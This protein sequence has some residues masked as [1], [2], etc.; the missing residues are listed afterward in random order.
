MAQNRCLSSPLNPFVPLAGGTEGLGGGDSAWVRT[1]EPLLRQIGGGHER[2]GAGYYFDSRV[3]KDEPH[4]VLQLTLSGAGFFE[5]RRRRTV[6]YPGMAFLHQIPGDFR[7]GYAPET[8]RDLH[9]KFYEQ[10]FISLAGSGSRKSSVDNDSAA[11]WY[12]RIT[13]THGHVLNFGEQN[14]IAPLLLRLADP[15]PRIMPRDR[16][17]ASAQI[18]QLLM[19]IL[20]TLNESRLAAT[21][22]VR[23]AVRLVNM[24]AAEGEFSIAGLAEALDCSR[25]HLTR[26]FRSALGV[27][28]AEYLMQQ[29]LRLVTQDL[30]STH[31][32]LDL[33]A[34]RCGFAGANY[35]CRAFRKH[36]GVSPAEFRARPWLLGP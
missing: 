31:D 18:Y 10:V 7:Y 22:L 15:V 35:L 34:Q 3:R 6:L 28:P 30:R 14:L 9:H 2:C 4:I 17:L 29:R 19:T 33:V 23:Q 36:L 25:E 16:Y 13:R 27:P 20:S 26:Q 8:V 32:K 11:A 5:K 1:R 24:R 12:Q 21:P